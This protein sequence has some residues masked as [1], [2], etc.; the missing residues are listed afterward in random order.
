MTFW[1]GGSYTN[2]TY[3][4]PNAPPTLAE[5]HCNISAVGSLFG[6]GHMHRSA[7]T[8]MQ[9]ATGGEP[10]STQMNLWVISAT[11]TNYVPSYLGDGY[12]WY[13]FLS[14]SPQD[15]QTMSILGSQ[16][17]ANGNL[18]VELPGQHKPKRDT[19]VHGTNQR[20]FHIQRIGNEIFSP[21][22]LFQR[23][24]RD[25]ARQHRQCR[26]TD[27]SEFCIF[28]PPLLGHCVIT[29]PGTTISNATS[30]GT[31]G[32]LVTNLQT[33]DG[34][35]TFCWTAPGQVRCDVLLCG[36]RAVRLLLHNFSA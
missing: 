35:A 21:A 11:A 9:L 2:L 18:A 16:L 15:P 30:S 20:L 1:P 34:S 10:G 29:V 26:A 31:G 17:D 5:E 14:S 24:R 4:G 3:E 25:G 12:P 32:T 13:Y 22:D 8:T 33:V 28:A 19:D 36:Q 23:K 27:R 6:T 7:D